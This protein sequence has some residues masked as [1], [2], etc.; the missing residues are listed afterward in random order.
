M[1]PEHHDPWSEGNQRA[2]ERLMALG[3][4]VEAGSRLAAENAR[5]KAN[6]AEQELRD[7]T[8]REQDKQ[9]AK[10]DEQKANRKAERLA[11]A[12]ASRR[13]REWVRLVGDENGLRGYLADLP[14]VEV[15]RHWGQAARN[16]DRNPTDAAVLTAAEEELRRR[17]PSLIDFYQRG[18]DA[19]LSRQDAMADAAR[20]VWSG[21]GPARP[22]GGQPS[23][24]GALTQVGDELDQEITRL[25]GT[26]DPVG[27]ARLLRNL[28]DSGWSAQSLA[29]IETL[30]DRAEA[31]QRTAATTEATPDDPA[32]AVNEHQAARAAAAAATGRAGDL[33]ADAS[34]HDATAP[35]A[36]RLAAESFALPAQRALTAHPSA[37]PARTP[38]AHPALR[39]T[40]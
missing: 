29:H 24:V 20:Y 23:T 30:L 22:H 1:E 2:M 9:K 5:A 28:E 13:K 19:G 31:E 18:R 16:A 34:A 4:L 7:Q 38:T 6:R 21:S 14:A 17:A 25:A 3:V 37:M 26:L 15:A 40:R 39:R 33:A 36:A 12:D 35:A 11:A 27:R 32:T 10:R 8:R